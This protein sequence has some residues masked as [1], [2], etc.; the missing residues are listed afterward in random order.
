ME[1][2]IKVVS[3]GSESLSVHVHEGAQ[4][5]VLALKQSI[6]QL[7]PARF[8][9]AAQRLIFQ[10][11]ILQNDQ[12][13][14]EYSISTGMAI[15][16]TL[17]PGAA[18][19]SAAVAPAQQTQ[20][21]NTSSSA[22]VLRSYLLQMRTDAGFDTAIQ[23][24]QKICENIVS[25]PT[26]DKY[27][28]LRV[29][30]AALRARLF[31]RV[32]GVDCIQLL[33]FEEGIEA[34]HYVLVPTAE[35]WEN[36]VM[37]KRV[38]DEYTVAPPVQAPSAAFA[39]MP[40][41]GFGSA[42]L[43]PPPD[44]GNFAAQAQSMLQN[45]MMLQ[46]LQNHPMIQQMAQSNP[47]VGQ[48]LQSPALLSQMLGSMQQN[49]MMMQQLTQMM[50]DPNAM[51]QMQRMMQ[52]GGGAYTPPHGPPATP[53]ANPFTPPTPAAANPFA[54][55]TQP[56]PPPAPAPVAAAPVSESALPSD[57]IFDEDEIA[58]AIARSLEEN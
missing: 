8:P 27:R 57:E 45:P 33:G 39:N 24:L 15:H 48:A 53:I 21:G 23:T 43:V 58:Q 1:L 40:G 41:F 42:P 37:L 46:I 4:A 50:Q 2:S 6:E 16:L 19:A 13:L 20:V 36:L 18:P 56:A 44:V 11:Q 29:G 35:R 30:N 55:F 14:A 17:A 47:L 25:H 28:K 31:D 12:R 7:N 5:S 34:G 38:L 3:S 49:P 52:A 10:G 51:T 26:E 9:V 54:A 22:Q 32:H